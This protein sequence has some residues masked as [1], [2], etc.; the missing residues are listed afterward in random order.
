MQKDRQCVT[1]DLHILEYFFHDYEI[2]EKTNS[3]WNQEHHH[4]LEDHRFQDCPVKI[5]WKI[6]KFHQPSSHTELCVSLIAPNESKKSL[7]WDSINLED[8]KL[9]LSD[10]MLKF[11]KYINVLRKIRWSSNI[12]VLQVQYR[13][14]L[15]GFAVFLQMKRSRP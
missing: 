10:A 11:L 7:R 3:P 12:Y 5:P 13:R 4:G 8:N 15:L 14:K 6:I 2:K 1:T 9:F